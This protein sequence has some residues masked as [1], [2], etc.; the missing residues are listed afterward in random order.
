MHRIV[1]LLFLA[2]FAAS[3]G[4][5]HTV[6]TVLLRAVLETANE[7]PPVTSEQGS[8]NTLILVHVNR[9]DDGK[10]TGGVVEFQTFF[11]FP[12]AEFTGHHIHEGPVG[13]NAG[14]VIGTDLSGTNRVAHP[15]GSGTLFRQVIVTNAE[16]LGRLLANPSG[17]YAN[18]HTVTNPGGAIRGQLVRPDTLVLRTPLLTRNE[19]PPTTVDASGSAIIRLFAERDGSGQ[20]VSGGAT[21]DVNYRFAESADLTGLHIHN[22]PAG[23]N[24]GIVIA[25][26]GFGG[27]NPL[28]GQTRGRYIEF[29]PVRT[30]LQVENL[31]GL[32]VNPQGFYANM[33]TTINP[34]GVIRGQLLNTG[35]IVFRV[36]MSPANEVPPTSVQ[37]SAP[38]TIT[39]DYT[40]DGSGRITGAQVTFDVNYS[41]FPPDTQFTGLHIH[42]GPA[43]QNA[44]VVIDSALPTTSPF[45][46]SATGTGNFFQFVNIGPD[47]TVALTNLNNLLANPSGF[48]V[49]LHTTVNPG[50]AIRSQ[51]G[52][53]ITAA[54]AIN[55]NGIVSAVLDPQITPAS[56]GALITIF[57]TNLAATSSDA[58]G[59][60]APFLPITM[61]GTEVGI[62]GRQAPLLFVSPTQINAQV[63][64]ETPNGNMEVFVK[65]ADVFGAPTRISVR[66]TSPGIFVT[67]LGAAVLKQDFSLVSAS[68]P[69]AAGDVILIFTTGGGK[70]TPAAITGQLVPSPGTVLLTVAQ[71]SVTIGGRTAD[72]LGSALAPGF[73]GLYQ[74]NVRVPA[75]VPAGNQPVVV[76]MGDQRSNAANIAVR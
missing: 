72:V 68:N 64:F 49:N 33:H 75:G 9:D 8:G 27:A 47:D 58:G 66:D 67:P 13:Q 42:N 56:P 39:I 48:Y 50:G 31:R 41:G 52:T 37:A 2:L 51:L 10:I 73:A 28:R 3:F 43:G 34:G 23:Q 21:F 38:A 1:C 59:L 14:V 65:R 7:V 76:T 35:R 60:E 6:D 70:T 24:A 46:K 61:N 40:R 20:I 71:P 15:G 62:A 74:V 30:P 16:L 69:A 22:G 12:A 54:P 32:F 36:D 4:W 57:G 11:N 63:P 17:F 29:V 53:P 19:V 26:T 25:T 18:L 5:G 45:T 44:G 55:N